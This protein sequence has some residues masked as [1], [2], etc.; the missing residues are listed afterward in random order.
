MATALN[1]MESNLAALS[2]AS[3]P[4]SYTKSQADAKFEAVDT[5]TTKMESELNTTRDELAATKADLQLATDAVAELKTLFA[6]F[7]ASTDEKMKDLEAQLQERKRKRADQDAKYNIAAT[8]ANDGGGESNVDNGGGAGDGQ[9]GPCPDQQDPPECAAMSPSG[10]GTLLAQTNVTAVCPNLCSANCNGGGDEPTS[11]SNVGMI[12]GIAASIFVLLA[13]VG[14]AV[15]VQ[16]KNKEAAD[17]E[18]HRAIAQSRGG[19]TAAI[20]NPAFDGSNEVV[21]LE[22]SSTQTKVY[23]DAAKAIE[24]SLYGGDSSTYDNA[25]LAAGDNLGYAA[26]GGAQQTYAGSTADADDDYDMPDGDTGEN[27]AV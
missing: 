9:E 19:P 7:K 3:E 8:T 10:C 26:M 25:S 1:A 22:P 23:D 2:S 11:T 21:Y 6:D 27:S 17:A 24:D 16:K 5:D 20:S 13:C 14:V 12:A 4:D 15:V 18:Q